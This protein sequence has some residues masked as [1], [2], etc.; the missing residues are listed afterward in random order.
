MIREYKNFN[1]RKSFEADGK[2]PHM[3]LWFQCQKL[4]ECSLHFK[5]RG[6]TT[7]HYQY[8]LK[9]KFNRKFNVYDLQRGH[10]IEASIANFFGIYFG[11]TLISIFEIVKFLLDK[12]RMDEAKQVSQR[13]YDEVH[14]CLDSALFAAADVPDVLGEGVDEDNILWHDEA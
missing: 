2:R 11:S 13:I 5:Q 4:F 12:K 10:E 8:D 6:F 7:F 1:I 9:C 3:K 14:C